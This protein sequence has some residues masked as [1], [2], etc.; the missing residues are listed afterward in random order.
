MVVVI[1]TDMIR[2]DQ[3]RI[4]PAAASV[5]IETL[6]WLFVGSVI[7]CLLLMFLFHDQKILLITAAVLGAA[8]RRPYQPSRVSPDCQPHE[9]WQR[10]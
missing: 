1:R 10:Q 7:G 2:G 6:T 8:C 4:A 5:F 3:V 9:S